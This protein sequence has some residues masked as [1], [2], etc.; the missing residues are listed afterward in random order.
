MGEQQWVG[1]AMLEEGSTVK[2]SSTSKNR[3]SHHKYKFQKQLE[4]TQSWKAQ[5]ALN[6]RRALPV[7]PFFKDKTEKHQTKNRSSEKSSKKINNDFLKYACW[8]NY[9]K[10]TILL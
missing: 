5:R 10:K 4:L 6:S 3:P 9:D 1:G 7:Y 8:V 2:G